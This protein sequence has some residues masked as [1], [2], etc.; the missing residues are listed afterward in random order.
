MSRLSSKNVQA[1]TVW[2][3]CRRIF[4]FSCVL[5]GGLTRHTVANSVLSP[6]RLPL[7][8]LLFLLGLFK[9]YPLHFAGVSGDLGKAS[10]GHFQQS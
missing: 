2:R 5:C 8:V 7:L 4:I 1:F 6:A 9:Y 3:I 10:H